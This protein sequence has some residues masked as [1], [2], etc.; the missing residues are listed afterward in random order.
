MV[1]ERQLEYNT[2]KIEEIQI[3]GFKPKTH[4]ILI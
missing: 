3:L 4:Q 2:I 1:E